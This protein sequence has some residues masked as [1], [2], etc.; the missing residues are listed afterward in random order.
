MK[1]WQVAVSILGWA[2]LS[3]VTLRW[4][5]SAISASMESEWLAVVIFGFIVIPGA[6]TVI[7]IYGVWKLGNRENS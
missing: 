3:V 4:M 1:S 2:L 6:I 7:F 5:S